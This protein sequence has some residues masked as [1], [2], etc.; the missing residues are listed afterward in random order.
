MN[1]YNDPFSEAAARNMQWQKKMRMEIHKRLQ[2][3]MNDMAQKY[4]KREKGSN[5]IELKYKTY[6]IKIAPFRA[7]IL[8]LSIC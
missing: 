5:P 3:K 7:I 1:Y 6:T 4:I 2:K 8:L